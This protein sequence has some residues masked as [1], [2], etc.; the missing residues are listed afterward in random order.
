[1]I[2]YQEIVFIIMDNKF[3]VYNVRY[4]E[5]GTQRMVQKPEGLRPPSMTVG[6]TTGGLV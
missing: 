2:I 4:H 6:L 1:M 5:A 3:K